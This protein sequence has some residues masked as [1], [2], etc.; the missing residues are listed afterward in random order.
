MTEHTHSRFFVA[1]MLSDEAEAYANQ[2]IQELG[3][4][5]NTRTAKAAPHITLQPPFLWPLAS[6]ETLEQTIA[7]VASTHAPIP[8][9]LRGFGCFSPRVLYIDVVRSDELLQV[10][11]NLMTQMETHLDIIDPKAKGRAFAP[12]VTVAS[13]RMTPGIFKRAWRDLG[14]REVAFE[15]VCDRLTLLIYTHDGNTQ[16]WV[17]H[18]TFS[19]L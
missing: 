15:F 17:T 1:L 4:R 6:V 19:F 18:Q 16:R 9:Q 12:H 14:D 3:D 13:R 5:Y 2:V 8:V 11:R 10:Q 7:T